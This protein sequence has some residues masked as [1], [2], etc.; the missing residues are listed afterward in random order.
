MLEI[1]NFYKNFAV[2]Y[3][4]YSKIFA[5]NF[6]LNDCSAIYCFENFKASGWFR[7]GS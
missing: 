6:L 7:I 2:Y 4:L 3:Y 1:N 5:E